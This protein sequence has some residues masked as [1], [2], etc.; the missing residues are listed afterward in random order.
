M[1]V[2]SL[3]VAAEDVT[4]SR[5][6]EIITAHKLGMA[7]ILNSKGELSGVFTDGDI[8]RTL[9]KFP[10]PSNLSIKDV[11]TAN[12]KHITANSYGASALNLMEK[13]SITALAVVDE[14]NK[15]VGVIH[16]HDLLKAGVA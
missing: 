7:M 4:F 16:I 8:R 3:P 5:V 6:V 11:M 12:P 14:N 1:K 9:M 13:Y 15:P 2:E 10:N